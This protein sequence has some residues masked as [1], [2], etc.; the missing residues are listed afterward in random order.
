MLALRSEDQNSE[1]EN[2]PQRGLVNC[3]CVFAQLC[4]INVAV[5][6]WLRKKKPVVHLPCFLLKNMRL[7]L[8][9]QLKHIIRTILL[10]E[11]DWKFAGA[12]VQQPKLTLWH[13]QI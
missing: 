13:G 5:T 9:T 11:F 6:P 7:Y 4:T 12:G 10:Q 8:H 1:R 2:S 3:F